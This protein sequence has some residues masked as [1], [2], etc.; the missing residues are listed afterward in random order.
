MKFKKPKFWDYKKKSFES[1]LLLPISI[2]YKFIFWIFKIL[3]SIKS[4]KS[5]IP[6][7]CVGNIYLGGTGKTPLVIEIYKILKSFGKNPA[8]IKKNYNYLTDEI[9]MLER[10]G[11]VYTNHKRYDGILLSASSKHDVAILDDGFQDFSIKPNFSIICFNSKQMIG[12]GQLI[13]SGP[14]RENL[15]AIQRADCV[16][17]NGDKNSYLEEKILLIKK[18]IHIFYTNYKIKNIEK[19]K[20]KKITAFAGIGNPINF[21][22]LLK[23]NKL[24]VVKTY[25]FPDH[26]HY[27]DNDFKIITKETSSLLVTTEKDFNRMNKEQREKCDVVEVTL[28][29]KNEQKFKELIKS[30]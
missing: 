13:P 5:I 10:T 22:E 25:A 19:F 30:Y 7:I 3:T 15:N 29:I 26:H 8:F 27:S 23:T 2:I 21:F 4:Q 9:K 20:D 11:K 1:I 12:N 17:I 24:D 6:V 28:E 16:V 14:L 18:N